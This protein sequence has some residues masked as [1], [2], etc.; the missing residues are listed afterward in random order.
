MYTP[1]KTNMDN[2]NTGDLI[3]FKN[4]NSCFG[5]MM[6]FFTGSEYTHVGIILKNPKFTN[7]PLVG[8][9]FW[10]S[11]NENYPDAED[12]KKKLGVE[13]VNLDELI[14]KCGSIK[15]YYRKLVLNRGFRID[16]DTLERVHDTVHN[17]PYD[18]VPK[19][20]IE[21]FFKYDSR[22]QKRDRFWCS[23]L[24]GYIYVQ[25]G[26][27]PYN[28]DWSIMRPN[29]FSTERKDLPLINAQLEPEVQFH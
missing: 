6:K 5:K 7:P 27:L 14:Q 19:D 25:L 11:C 1:L 18:I 10:E 17:K 13:I 26:L 16:E 9:F 8:L 15:L 24:T 21:A 20:W 3:L 22:P 23:A 12:H 2:W 29:D 28:T 4:L